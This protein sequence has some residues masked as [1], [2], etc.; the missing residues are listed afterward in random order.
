M[1]NVFHNM[2]LCTIFTNSSL[3]QT[4]LNKNPLKSSKLKIQNS[5]Q[6]QLYSC[7]LLSH[8]ILCFTAI[9]KDPCKAFKSNA[10]PSVIELSTMIQMFTNG[11]SGS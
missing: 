4:E 6:H 11:I 1:V 3:T 10:C 2:E 5:K 8:Y 9:L 7:K